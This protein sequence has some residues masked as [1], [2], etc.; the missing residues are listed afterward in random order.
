MRLEQAR[1]H[2]RHL[3]AA[4]RRARHARDLGDVARIAHGDAAQRLHPLGDRVDQHELLPGVLVE[5]QVQLVEGRPPHQP[6][7]LLV[8][9]DQDLRVGQ[10]LIEPLAGIQPGLLRQGDRE[11]AHGAERLD[12]H[13]ALVQPRLT[14]QLG[15]A[16]RQARLAWSAWR[17]VLSRWLAEASWPA[18]SW[19]EDLKRPF[20]GQRQ[21]RAIEQGRSPRDAR[22]MW[23]PCF[24]PWARGSLSRGC[25]RKRGE[26]RPMP[27]SRRATRPA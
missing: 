12:L 15:T 23:R 9:R 8:Q 25:R 14:A 5:Q 18:C 1:Q 4:V 26:H 6:V 27:E 17:T 19:S 13:A 3:L 22:V 7:V 11:L 16:R 24:M 21:E 10:E 2:R 20:A